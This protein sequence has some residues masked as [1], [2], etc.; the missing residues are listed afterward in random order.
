MILVY[1]RPSGSK[2]NDSVILSTPIGNASIGKYTKWLRQLPFEKTS[3]TSSRTNLNRCNG[4]SEQRRL[5]KTTASA[6]KIS[7]D[8]L[9]GARKE[10]S[11]NWIK[12]PYVLKEN[13]R[14]AL[15]PMRLVF[16][17]TFRGYHHILFK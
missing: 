11:P 13:N 16:T 7:P 1:V 15:I 8:H 12:V 9:N 5:D 14:N 17:K 2:V 10:N 4:R 6:L 3:H